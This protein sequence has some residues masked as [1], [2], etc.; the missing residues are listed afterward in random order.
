MSQA[1]R[2]APGVHEVATQGR[3]GSRG[4]AVPPAA[5]PDAPRGWRAC[6]TMAARRPARAGRGGRHL[7]RRGACRS[8]PHDFDFEF[9]GLVGFEDPL[10]A[11]VPAAIALVRP[12]RPAGEDDHRRLP[13]HRAGHRPPGRHRRRRGRADRRRGGRAGRRGAGRGAWRARNVFARIRPE[14]KLRLVE[15]LKARGD[16][17]AMTGDGVN[18]APALKAAHIGI[19]M[20][21]RGSDVARE[22]SGIVL[23]DEDFGRI[24]EGVRRG[25]AHLRQPAQGD[26]LH[27]GHAHPD[28]RPG[29]AAAADRPAAA[30]AAGARG[31]GGDDRRP[32]VLDRLRE[33]TAPNPT[34]CASRRAG[35]PSR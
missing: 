8:S 15:A 29:H 5:G 20:G 33:R 11:S 32:D 26:D 6:S 25:P 12:G 22:A 27:R 24:V 9:V 17:V 34:P 18:D 10:R 23:L 30:A 28:C 4:R 31:A 3:A 21:Q 35:W 16:V 1:W 2:S 19:A 7:P 13:R 14:Q